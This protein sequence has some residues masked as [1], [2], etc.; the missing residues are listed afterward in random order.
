MANNVLKNKMVLGISST[1]QT[2]TSRSTHAEMDAVRKFVKM[3]DKCKEIDL[4]VV[5]VQ[6]STNTLN[7]SRPC[8]NCLIRLAKS[9]KMHRFTI[10]HI[11]YSTASGDIKRENF[12]TM[13]D[14][15][16]TYIAT[17]FRLGRKKQKN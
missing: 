4:L 2:S 8:R 10:K 11:Y 9:M 7:E 16:M 3:R 5:K 14:S 13:L 17:G 15:P 6:S 12:S 1:K